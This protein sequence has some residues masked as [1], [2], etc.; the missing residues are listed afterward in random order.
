MINMPSDYNTAERF[1]DFTPLPADGYVCK[2]M[3]MSEAE[4]KAGNQM[5]VLS[6]D[7]A[8]GEFKDHFM[9]Q[10]KADTK[11]DKKWRCKFYQLTLNKDGNT[12][13]GFKNLVESVKESNP[14]FEPK[15]GEGFCE[16]FNG[17]LVGMV[18]GNEEYRKNDGSIGNSVKPIKAKNIDD[19]R[20]GNYVVPTDKKLN[21]SGFNRPIA[22][23]PMEGIP[24]G[25]EM[26]EEDD[27][28]F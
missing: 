6:L 22:S 13:G 16:S 27:I 23:N 28:P 14:G 25:F 4:S 12:N 9:N 24:K 1:G 15:W 2:I 11:E 21:D 17:K 19:I 3:R 10:Y 7:I 5:V 8:E 20:S 18:F 26:I